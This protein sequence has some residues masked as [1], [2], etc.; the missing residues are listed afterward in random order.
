M[1]TV[2]AGVAERYPADLGDLLLPEPAKAEDLAMR[3]LRWRSN[4]EEFRRRTAPVARLL[5]AYDWDH[6]ARRIV[7][8]VERTQSL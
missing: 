3:L 8:L 7:A 6:M 5:R 1:V 4:I 2:S